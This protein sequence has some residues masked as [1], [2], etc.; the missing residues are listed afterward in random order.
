[1]RLHAEDNQVLLADA[2][3]TITRRDAR[4]DLLA[5]FQQ[6]RPFSTML[7]RCAPRAMTLTSSPAW[8]SLAA[9]RPPIAPAPITHIFK[10]ECFVV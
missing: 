9:N 2:G 3:D 10:Y 1:M 6:R 4:N 8:A 5:F 7:T